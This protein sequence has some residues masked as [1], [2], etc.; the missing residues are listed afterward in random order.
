LCNRHL[1]AHEE[2]R[3]ERATL[4]G[5]PPLEIGLRRSPRARRFSL[6]VS[7]ADG[8]VTLSIPLRASRDAALDFA[9]EK[10]AWLRDTLASLPPARKVAPGGSILFQGREIP[11]IATGLLRRARLE[12]AGLLVPSGAAAGPAAAAC[13]R[14]AA[15]VRLLA[16]CDA[17]AAELGRRPGRITCA[18]CDRAGAPAR[19]RAI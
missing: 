10:E 16:A 14:E 9:R 12:D 1:L 7:R 18:T 15:R 5:E 11:V 6:R 17:H 2:A 3:L 8:R 4:P 13:L 19:P